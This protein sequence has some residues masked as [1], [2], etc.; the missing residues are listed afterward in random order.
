MNACDAMDEV[1]VVIDVLADPSFEGVVTWLLRP[2][3]PAV[4]LAGLGL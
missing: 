4:L 1:L 2:V 3:G